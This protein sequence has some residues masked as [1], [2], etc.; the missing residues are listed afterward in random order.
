[1]VCCGTAVG[2]ADG[3][4]AGGVVAGSVVVGVFVTGAVA[5]ATSSGVGLPVWVLFTTSRT[6]RPTAAAASV[7]NG[8]RC[9]ISSPRG[10]ALIRG[11][12]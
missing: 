6:T 5:A 10:S 3:L 8:L 1:M 7:T 11:S 2:V 9:P 12:A 4:V